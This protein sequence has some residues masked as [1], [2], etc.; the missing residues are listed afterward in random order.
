MKNE[1]LEQVLEVAEA[2]GRAAMEHYGGDGLV[3]YK[4]DDS[5]LTLADKAA[6]FVIVNALQVLDPWLPVLSEESPEEEISERK[7]WSDFWVVDPLDGSKEFIKQS[8]EFTVNIARVR[9]GESVLGV[10]HA[11]VTG[12]CY[13][14]TREGGA[15]VRRADGGTEEIFVRQADS[16][17]LKIVAS[18]DHA[19]PRVEALLERL[20]GAECVSMGSSL[21][22]CLVAEGKADFYPRLVPTMEW[23]TAAAQC[24]LEAAGGYL[25]DLDGRRLSY[26]KDDLRNPSVLAYGDDSIDWVAL[27]GED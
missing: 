14:A 23:D 18:K 24:V 6:H 12:E 5:P 11:P 21:K 26:N 15:F 13:Y 20:Q 25:V 2:A 7:S 10:V 19:G 1:L 4:E 8:G 27:L 9:G 22:F 3:E 17:D 16:S